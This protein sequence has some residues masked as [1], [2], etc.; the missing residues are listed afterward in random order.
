VIPVGDPPPL[1]IVQLPWNDPVSEYLSTLSVA[2]SSTTQMDV[3]SVTMSLGSLFWLMRLKLLAAFW[4]PDNRL[5]APV[6]FEDFVL[7][8]IDD[9]N[10][11]AVGGDAFDLGNIQIQ[12]SNLGGTTLGL[13]SGH[14]IWLDDNA[15]GWG[16]F[17]DP[18]PQ[19]DSEF[20]TPGNQGEQNPSQQPEFRITR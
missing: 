13:A 19:D 18:T 16:W 3:P 12:I 14:T 15:A 4:L 10:V 20:T 2:E 6:Y 11:G 17:V 9:P 8:G 1:V 5:A 7:L